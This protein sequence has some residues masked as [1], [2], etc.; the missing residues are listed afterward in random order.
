MMRT[1]LELGLAILC[2]VHL[3]ACSDTEPGEAAQPESCWTARPDDPGFGEPNVA[4]AAEMQAVAGSADDAPFYMLNLIKFREQ[5]CYPDGRE[6]DLTGREADA[7]YAPIDFLFAIG[8][9]PVF[10]ADVEQTLL[11]DGVKWD[12]VAIVLYPSR[13]GFLSMVNDEEFQAR[14]IHKRAGIEKSIVMVSELLPSTLPP[15]YDPPDSPYPATAEDTAVEIVHLLRFNEQAQYPDGSTEDPRSGREAMELYQD[16]ATAGALAI[17]VY[18]TAWF[19]VSDVLIGDGREWDELRINHM[20]SHAA[21]QAFINQEDRK[22][23]EHHRTAALEDSY[24]VVS[25]P[26]INALD[27]TK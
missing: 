13:E 1:M 25:V 11:G 20:P 5:A 14:T 18:P 19:A 24:T 21:Y 17:G 16:G 26:L 15:D 2:C 4:V 12:Q 9:K 27:P 23:G 3:L 22:A 6:T 7:L 8:A 10:V